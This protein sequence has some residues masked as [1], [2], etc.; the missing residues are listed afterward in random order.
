MINMTIGPIKSR[1]TAIK[2]WRSTSIPRTNNKFGIYDMP[3]N[4]L[5]PKMNT[6]R[7]KVTSECNKLRHEHTIR[8]SEKDQTRTYLSHARLHLCPSRKKKTNREYS[9]IAVMANKLS[10]A[11]GP[12]YSCF[13]IY[14]V[15]LVSSPGTSCHLARWLSYSNDSFGKFSAH[16]VW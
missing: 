6:V 2:T 4:R 11:T 16:H 5:G 13:A 1:Y 9:R 8:T 10:M 14:G 3:K 15:T 12:W 7:Q